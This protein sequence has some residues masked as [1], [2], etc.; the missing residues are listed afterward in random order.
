MAYGYDGASPFD[1]N[2]AKQHG[3]VLITGYLVG[4]PGGFDP[5][6]KARVDQIRALGMGFLPNW[7]RGAAYLVSCGKGGGEAAGREAVAALRALGVPG[8]GT[9]ACAFSWD[10]NVHPSLYPQCGVVAD[11]IIAGLAGG[12]LFSAYGQGG[13]L[14]WFH[15]TGRMHVK[16]W[17]SGS[18]SFPG[19]NVAGPNVGMVQSH[20]AAGEWLDTGVA[21]TDINTV[22]DPHAL[23]AWWSAGSPYTNGDDMSAADVAAINK[24]AD[25][26]R[27][28]EQ[29][30]LKRLG[31]WLAGAGNSVFNVDT[32]PKGLVSPG[33]RLAA[34]QAASN[35]A[36]FAA[37][38]APLLNASGP[39]T[40]AT[41]EQALRAV[42][43]SVDNVPAGG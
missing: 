36:A 26:L 15:A 27:K 1:L 37:A 38:L 17:L 34:L 11:G 31:Q 25:E 23:G 18:S 29:D 35:P 21:G 43:G 5:I 10:T 14:D 22:I 6:S 4:S 16:G 19:F 12:Y 24:H 30:D 41:L 2:A 8:D 3:A 40:E 39:V 7:E 28:A 13:L 33:T 20:N 32:M 42:L 9:V